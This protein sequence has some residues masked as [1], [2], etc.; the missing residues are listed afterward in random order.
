MIPE[1]EHEIFKELE[2]LSHR[3]RN[4]VNLLK[5]YFQ[6]DISMLLEDNHTDII[7]VKDAARE[8]NFQFLSAQ[9]ELKEVSEEL[10][11]IRIISARL[12]RKIIKEYDK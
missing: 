11:Q 7:A 10:G 12:M 5:G 4:S 3:A 8:M 9:K 2:N 1:T 6:N